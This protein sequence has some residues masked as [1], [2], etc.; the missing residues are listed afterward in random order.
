M[1]LGGLYSAQLEDDKREDSSM[2]IGVTLFA[3][4]YAM[5]PDAFARAC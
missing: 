5:R 3:T 4:D 2:K 1:P